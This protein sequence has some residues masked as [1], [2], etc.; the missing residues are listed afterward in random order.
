MSLVDPFG[1]DGTEVNLPTARDQIRFTLII[2]SPEPTNQQ[3]S[4]TSWPPP[5]A[6]NLPEAA[7]DVFFN[8][9]DKGFCRVLTAGVYKVRT[10][11]PYIPAPFEGGAG[12]KR[13]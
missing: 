5:W 3:S 11:R 6:K 1:L 4:Q 8:E 7:G 9:V 10:P 2:P 12:G 13:Y